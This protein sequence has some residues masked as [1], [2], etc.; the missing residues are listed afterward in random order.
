MLLRAYTRVSKGPKGF[1]IQLNQTWARPGPYVGCKS[2][3]SPDLHV[4]L[5]A[6]AKHL[7]ALEFQLLGEGADG[8]VERVD[9]AVQVHD[10][11]LPTRH[12]L[13]QV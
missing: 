2:D 10:A 7:F 3:V 12:L 6:N 13:L 5:A 8:L 1:E 11:L 9:L 4:G